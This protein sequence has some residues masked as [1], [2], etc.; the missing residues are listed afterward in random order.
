MIIL[1][2]P[3]CGHEFDAWQEFEVPG[4]ERA[5]QTRRLYAIW[6]DLGL[7]ARVATC[8]AREG[9]GDVAVV[10][11]MSDEELLDILN[12]G[13]VALADIRALVPRDETLCP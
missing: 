6:R 2:C 4:R 10:A 3:E 1:R 7:N 5:R 13:Q 8:L 11:A 12:V 9:I